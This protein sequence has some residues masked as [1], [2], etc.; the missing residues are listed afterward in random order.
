MQR[1]LCPFVFVRAAEEW[2]VGKRQAF[3]GDAGEQAWKRMFVL[4]A[5]GFLLEMAEVNWH[6]VAFHADI[7]SKLTSLLFV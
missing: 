7:F 4:D 6:D 1:S 3:R 2:R 5:L